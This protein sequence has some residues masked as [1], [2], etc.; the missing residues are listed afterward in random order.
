MLGFL[1]DPLSLPLCLKRT[2]L[3]VLAQASLDRGSAGLSM[4]TVVCGVEIQ[5]CG[6]KPRGKSS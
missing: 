1:L 2:E 6:L 4:E 5:G 3:C